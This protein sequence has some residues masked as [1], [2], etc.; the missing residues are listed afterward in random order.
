[1]AW[2]AE[3]VQN[4]IQQRKGREPRPS[5]WQSGLRQQQQRQR[6]QWRGGGES[7]PTEA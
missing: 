1:M 2:E 6:G 5:S 3:A 7:R 4:Q